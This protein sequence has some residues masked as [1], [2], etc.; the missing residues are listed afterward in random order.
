M[1]KTAEELYPDEDFDWG[2]PSNYEPIYK[3]F[4]TLVRVDHIG[5]YQGDTQ[6]LFYDDEKKQHGY[7]MFGWGS[8]TVCDRLQGCRNYDDVNDLIDELYQSVRWFDDDK[9]AYTFFTTHEW[10]YDFEHSKEFVSF[11]TEFFKKRLD[12]N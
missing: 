12:E 4:G 7:M 1:K 6:V 3:S 11:C 8:C 5:E 9:E 10:D 2:G